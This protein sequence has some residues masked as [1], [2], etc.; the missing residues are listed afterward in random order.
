MPFGDKIAALARGRGL[1]LAALAR[2]AGVT[3][4]ALTKIMRG[5]FGPSWPT[6]QRLA[7]VLDCSTDELRDSIQLPAVAP[8]GKPGRPRTRKEG[9]DGG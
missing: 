4:S 9:I 7:L 5:D 1:T 3:R 8:L 2:Q 6:V